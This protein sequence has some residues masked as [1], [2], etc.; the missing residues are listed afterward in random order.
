VPELPDLRIL[1]DAFTAALSGRPLLGIVVT[2]PLVLRGTG[3]ELHGLE[4]AVLDH[5]EQRGKFLTLHLGPQRVV[6]NAMLTGRLGLAAPGAKAF[7]QTA[8]VFTFGPREHGSTPAT[9]SWTRGASWLPAVD[10]PVELRYRDPKKMGK[11]YVLPAGVSREVAGWDSLGPDADDPRLDVDRWQARIRKHNG[12]LHNLLKNQAFVAGIGN[13]YSD[14]VLWEARLAPFRKR[15]S[16]AAEESERLWRASHD[17]LSWAIEE[18]RERVPPTFERQ[19]RDFLRVHLK[20]GQPCPRCG[21]T[22]S[23]V[24]PGGF[25][26]TW[27]R[28]C[29]V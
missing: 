8:V 23:E 7:P 20:G 28:S 22:L 10:Q 25:T 13:A 29:Q 6:V 18:L 27:C 5:V 26:T 9:A 12:E 16:L 17:V 4:G 15:T 19:A 2:Q 14:E 11:V 21:S 24:S 3:A 1:A